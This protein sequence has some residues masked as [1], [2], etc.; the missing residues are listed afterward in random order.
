MMMDL[1]TDE[2]E[3]VLKAAEEV[4]KSGK[5]DYLDDLID[6]GGGF[7]QGGGN[8]APPRRRPP[9]GSK[10]KVKTVIKPSNNVRI[11]GLEL[12]VNPTMKCSRE[13]M[14][15]YKY[16]QGGKCYTYKSGDKNSRKAA[17]RKSRLQG[18]A[19]EVS[20]HL[21]G[22]EEDSSESENE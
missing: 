11:A 9:M 18:V 12:T 14:P 3:E 1:T 4:I 15:G 22:M 6:Q 13:G 17:L 2:S 7:G 16:G 5:F 8:G 20:K 19:I 10:P 21:H